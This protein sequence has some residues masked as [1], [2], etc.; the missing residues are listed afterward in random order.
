MLLFAEEDD[1]DSIFPLVAD[2]SVQQG[3]SGL[4]RLYFVFGL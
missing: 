3:A 1:I 2:C 4:R